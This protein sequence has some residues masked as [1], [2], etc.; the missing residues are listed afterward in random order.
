MGYINEFID[1][2]IMAKVKKKK[3]RQTWKELIE[4]LFKKYL[5]EK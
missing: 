2:R 4:E 5:E 3:G 1:D